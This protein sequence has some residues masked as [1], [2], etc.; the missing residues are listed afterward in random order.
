MGM[1]P[2]FLDFEK[3]IVD[4]QSK[5]EALRETELG[6]N[7]DIAAEIERLEKKQEHLTHTIFNNLNTWQVVQLSRHSERP[8]FNF[9]LTHLFTEFDLLAGDRH[10]KDDKAILG[11]MG[12][13]NNIPVMVIGHQKGST[14]Q[15]KILHNFGMPKPEG[16]RKALRLIRLAEQFHLPIIS[17]IDTPGAYPGMDAEARNQSEAIALNLQV[18]S[19]VKTPVISVVIGEGGSGGALAIGVSDITLMFQYSIYSVISPEGCASIL[20]RD[21]AKAS[22]AAEAM[23]V[24]ADRLFELGLIDEVIPEPLGGAHRDPNF[25]VNT[26][27]SSLINHLTTLI[28]QPIDQL[29]ENRYQGLLEIGRI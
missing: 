12:R 14:T 9:Y 10:F 5:I 3:P 15:E 19:E 20:W 16:Y 1:Q 23:G 22:E 25:M 24:T 27:K 11:G 28:H 6:A 7:F 29:V 2:H 18:L 21:A 26:L 17:F 8:R 13:L 4:L